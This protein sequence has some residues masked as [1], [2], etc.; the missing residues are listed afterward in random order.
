MPYFHPNQEGVWSLVGD[1]AATLV[2]YLSARSV[3]DSENFMERGWKMRSSVKGVNARCGMAK[4][5]WLMKS[6][7]KQ[8][9][10]LSNA[11]VVSN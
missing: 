11:G 3:A 2:S 5:S 4:T 1:G 9:V 8:E 10:A 7:C 6:K